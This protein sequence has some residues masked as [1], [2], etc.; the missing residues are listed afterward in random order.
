VNEID[1]L[2]FSVFPSVT[3]GIITVSFPA[4]LA[5]AA[6]IEVRD[7]NG[8]LVQNTNLGAG[9]TQTLIDLNAEADGFYLV[10]VNAG[11]QVSTEM[12]VKQH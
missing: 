6:Q 7:M 5:E 10:R 1:G 4:P 8:R 11:L 3:D 2:T 9:M 12:V